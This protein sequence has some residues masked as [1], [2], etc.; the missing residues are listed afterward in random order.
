MTRLPTAIA[1]LGLTLALAVPA[2]VSISARAAGVRI[3]GILPGGG[4]VYKKVKTVREAR[5]S[6][7]VRQKTDY[8]CGAAAI[9]T[10]LKYAYGRD[11]GEDEVLRGMM[12]IS[13]PELVRAKGF[14]LLDMKNYVDTLGLEG[15]G[16]RVPFELLKNL[17]FPA[18]TLL[19]TTGYRHFVVLKKATEDKVYLA[20]PALGNKAMAAKDF[21]TG[22]NGVIFVVIGR[23]YDR[24]T[25][26]RTSAKSLGVRRYALQSLTRDAAP[27][28]FGFAHADYFR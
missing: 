11:V 14:S 18:I 24:E 23:G 12:R 15:R 13:D 17:K 6:D 25:V 21:I 10:L 2:P 9:A 7:L 27:L 16:Y 1:V 8:S 26:L 4:V 22:W 20:D 19:D 28:G 3:G 5:Y